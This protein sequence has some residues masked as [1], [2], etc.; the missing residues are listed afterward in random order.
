M[1]VWLQGEV[2]DSTEDAQMALKLYR[3]YQKVISD[4]NG[5]SFQTT[6]C[7][8]RNTLGFYRRRPSI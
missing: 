5:Q 3:H 4:K 6:H 1:I 7:P 2:H 8:Q